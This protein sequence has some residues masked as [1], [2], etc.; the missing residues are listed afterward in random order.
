M[1]KQIVLKVCI[2]YRAI[3]FK[4]L[5]TII[6]SMV[7]WM[8]IVY[9]EEDSSTSLG[10]VADNIRSGMDDLAKLVTSMFFVGG[11]CTT[12]VGLNKFKS[13]INNPH[14]E[15]ISK[16]FVY[17]TIGIILCFLPSFFNVGGQTIFGSSPES[18]G[19][20]GFDGLE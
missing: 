3:Q 20:D 5:I 8:G 19:V 10:D 17:T 4:K 2:V 18:A 13:Y 7:C 1:F 12:C 11:L 15:Q 16:G 6:L 14:Q 9:A